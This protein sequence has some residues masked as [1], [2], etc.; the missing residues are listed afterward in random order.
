MK[1]LMTALLAAQTELVHIKPDKR[2]AYANYDYVSHPKMVEECRRVLLKN[3]L[4]ATCGPAGI[5]FDANGNVMV[6]A[7]FHLGH[8]QSGEASIYPYTMPL[9]KD[10]KPDD[11]I[12]LGVRTTL[13]RYWLRDLLMIPCD[14]RED[15]DARPPPKAERQARKAAA[16]V[17]ADTLGTAFARKL[18]DKMQDAGLGMDALRKDIGAPDGSP[19]TWPKS[20][21]P[22]VKEWVENNAQPAAKEQ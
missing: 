3:G 13:L 9:V 21:G 1:N 12:I 16:P 5:E 10:K 20:F 11:K 19:D 2:N 22:K 15:I 4:V 6:K 14:D 8:A 18:L 17:Q 7:E